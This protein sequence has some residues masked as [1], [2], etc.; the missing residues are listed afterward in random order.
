MAVAAGT[1]RSTLRG[2]FRGRDNAPDPS[3]LFR[4]GG[5]H[6]RVPQPANTDTG[7]VGLVGSRIVR[8]A[9]GNQDKSR[10]EG[11]W[12]CAR[13]GKDVIR[14]ARAKVNVV[15]SYNSVWEKQFPGS[16]SPPPAINAFPAVSS[17]AVYPKSF[18]KTQ[19]SAS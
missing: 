2:A 10:W 19:F 14:C 7:E 12:Q 18:R 17:V 13:S 4:G 5:G 11:E 15:G 8:C 16:E 3:P 9:T 1:G 6:G